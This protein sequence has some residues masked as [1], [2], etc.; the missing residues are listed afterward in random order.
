M[1]RKREPWNRRILDL[2]TESGTYRNQFGTY[3]KGKTA[4][5]R[6][7]VILW[8]KPDPSGS[9]LHAPFSPELL[10]GPFSSSAECTFVWDQAIAKGSEVA[11]GQEFE[12]HYWVRRAN[13][14][15][16]GLNAAQ[17]LKARGE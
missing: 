8:F 15:Y 6:K 11:D 13:H 16:Q 17:R 5:S 7:Y 1:A 14:I 3:K 12:L 9:W 10:A 2:E 4:G